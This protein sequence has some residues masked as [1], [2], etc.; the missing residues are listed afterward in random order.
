MYTDP[1]QVPWVTGER[2]A[3][4]PARAA[5]GSRTDEPPGSRVRWVLR[6]GG[7]QQRRWPFG[8][9]DRCVRA[10]GALQGTGAGHSRMPDQQR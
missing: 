7:A 4:A 8:G 10:E 6:M 9:S 1:G 3:P 5:V 2:G